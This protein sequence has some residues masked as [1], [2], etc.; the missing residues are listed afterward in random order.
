[1]AA[2]QSIGGD[3][4][5][6]NK[7]NLLL[8]LLVVGLALFVW[9]DEP[10][11]TESK[12]SPL[13][14]LKEGEVT[15][16]R[17]TKGGVTTLL[18]RE[19]EGEQWQLTQP[20]TAP[21]QPFKVDSLLA[22]LAVEPFNRFSVANE[23][24]LAQ[25]GLAEPMVEVAFNQGAVTFKFGAQTALDRRRYVA[26]GGEVATIADYHYYQAAADYNDFINPRLLPNNPQL[27]AF[28][29]PEFTLRHGESGWAIEP[30]EPTV[31]A[32]SVADWVDN[33]KYTSALSVEALE[34]PPTEIEGRIEIEMAAGE[35][36]TWLL[37]ENERH[38]PQLYRPDLKLLY[39]LPQSQRRLFERPLSEVSE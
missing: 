21:V 29:L 36:V 4:A 3:M 20:I 34:E 25:Y 7:L 32:D 9:F 22:L 37:S 14:L 8:A 35:R 33:W 26:I 11:S 13:A 1:M 31:S 28:I 12:P 38:E 16:I 30:A 24:S 27:V 17:L 18:V 6:R 15:D 2:A 10:P 39:Q 5:K 19:S 23:A